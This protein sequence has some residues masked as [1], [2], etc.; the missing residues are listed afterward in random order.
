MNFLLPP[1]LDFVFKKL[2][3]KDTKLLINLINSVLE[4]PE[5]RRILSVEIKNP[6]ILQEEIIDKYNKRP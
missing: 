3:T 2:F 1:T 4:L 6:A 5:H